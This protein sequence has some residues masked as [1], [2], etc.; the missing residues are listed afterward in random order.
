MEAPETLDAEMTRLDPEARS[1]LVSPFPQID[2]R[3]VIPVNEENVGILLARGFTMMEVEDSDRVWFD[4][5]RTA[6]IVRPEDDLWEKSSYEVVY[7]MRDVSKGR[8]MMTCIRK[9]P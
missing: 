1:E 5:G 8:E 4:D 7:F 3:V 6:T 2:G 9:I